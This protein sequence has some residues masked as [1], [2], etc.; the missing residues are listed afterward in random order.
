MISQIQ[1]TKGSE[2]WE[3]CRA[4]IQVL[5]R[6]SYFGAFGW[7]VRKERQKLITALSDELLGPGV[8]YEVLT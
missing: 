8:D 4:A 7:E 6:E 5:M 1:M 3:K 2:H